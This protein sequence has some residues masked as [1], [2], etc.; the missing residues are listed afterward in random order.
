MCVQPWAHRILGQ[1][2][3]GAPMYPRPMRSRASPFHS[4]RGMKMHI[5]NEPCAELR[6]KACIWPSGEGRCGRPEVSRCYDLERDD[7]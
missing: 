3:H 5:T 4:P 2:G 6:M 7:Q 1:T